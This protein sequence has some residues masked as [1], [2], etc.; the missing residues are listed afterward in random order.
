M[1]A[2][3]APIFFARVVE[4]VDTQDLKSCEVNNLVPVQVWPRAPAKTEPEYFAFG[5][6]YEEP[7]PG[8][9]KGPRRMVR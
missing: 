9:E 7:Y 4:S 1:L 2:L 6:I 5:Q 3:Q 8:T